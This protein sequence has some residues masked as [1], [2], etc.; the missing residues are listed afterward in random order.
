MKRNSSILRSIGLIFLFAFLIAGC[1]IFKKEVVDENATVE[2]L[3]ARAK[4]NLDKN[5]WGAAIRQLQD[6]EA[7][8]PYGVYAEQAQL[9]TAFAHFK[10]NQPGLATTAAD[11][12][13]KLHPTHESVDYAYYLKGLASFEED[14]STIGYLLGK[15][16]LS[17]RDPTLILKALNAFRDVYTLFPE[18]RYAASSK[19]RVG[20]LSNAMAKH[21]INIANYY[22]SKD[23]YVAVVNRAKV[24]I[25]EYPDTSSAE[26]ALGLLYASYFKMGLD[27]LAEDS[28]R[29]LELNFPN[30]N[31]LDADGI[32]VVDAHGVRE[33]KRGWFS[34]IRNAFK[35]SP[36]A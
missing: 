33:K 17:D 27:D 9:D 26:D 13:I 18:S 35:R 23:A 7:K 8:Y 2:E 14:K 31:Y 28:R 29:V 32:D 36:S 3:Y 5:N 34:F 22:F 25:E 24:V 12:F 1:S 30:S 21:E 10:S 19:E 4:Q 15:N 16:D 20:Y 11:R 6:L